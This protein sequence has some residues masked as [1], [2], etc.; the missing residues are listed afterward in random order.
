VAAAWYRARGELRRSWRSLLLLVL[1]VGVAGGAVLTTVAGARRSSTA[2][3]RFR[4]ATFASDMDVAFVDGPPDGDIAAAA[5]TIA[6]MPEVAA[7]ARFDF[8]FIVPAKSGL[9]PFL[10]F[11]AIAHADEASYKSDVDRSRI[12]AG[13]LPD[14]DAAEQIAIREGFAKEA[15]LE[16]GDRIEVE[17]YAPAQLDQLFTTG[18]A[19]P[20]AGP[21]LTL[22]VTGVVDV[23]SF[24][25]E[26]SGDF[27]PSLL[28]SPAFVAEHG[29]EIATYPG[30]FAV[31]L[32]PEADAEEVA[33]SLRERFAGAPLEI[34]LSSEV[35]RKIQSS[36]DVI[37]T[38]LG[39]CALVAA[40]AGCMAVGQALTRH[41]ASQESGD[42]WLSALGMTRWERVATKTATALP[43][44]VLGALLAVATCVLLSPLMPVGVA[45]RAEPDPGLAVDWAA[46]WIGGGVTF[47][48]VLSLSVL[49]AA[50][51]SRRERRVVA[52]DADSAASRTTRAMRR[53]NLDP[54]TTIGVG[55]ALEP[56]GGT[57]FA[58]RSAFLGAAFGVTGLV[59]VVVFVASVDGLARSPARYGAPFDALVSGFSGN[60][61]EEG[62]EELLEDPRVDGVVALGSG[63]LARVGSLEANTISL[64]SLKG[65]LALTMLEG[66]PPT[67]TAEVV[68]GRDTLDDAGLSVGDEVDVDGA[69][70][71]L[72]ATVVGIAVFPVIDERS[73][74][75]RGVLMG[76][77]DL[78][79]ITD[80]EE[81]NGDVIIDWADG[82]DAEAANAELAEATGTEVFGP[83]LPSDVNNLQDVRA[84]PRALAAFLGLLA[85]L[86]VLHALISTVRMRR[87]EL[88]VLRALGFERRQLGSTVTWQATTI[89]VVGLL[90]GVP[91]GLVVGRVVWRAVASGIGVVDD[92]VT[93]VAAVVLVVVGELVVVAA[94]AILPGRSARRVSPATALRSA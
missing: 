87:Q 74:P 94:M 83:R 43:V 29:D 46:V 88:A 45:R 62:G 23:P 18:D 80:P 8:P 79:R 17:S 19:G 86:A 61:L 52:G 13:T 41:F 5:E 64:E 48:A 75:G 56:R 1:L 25:S 2:Y 10:E 4:E 54:S 7:L 49:A 67:G 22:V 71:T 63:G 33:A 36:I 82:V 90:V 93:P 20:P 24:L 72:R 40:L 78:E 11:L 59:G 35:D 28:L 66:H 76:Q 58:V 55:M 77:E 42:R 21:R 68:L 6:A 16:V 44:A 15:E 26:S 53:A 91:V 37:V 38:A 65:D 14:A 85:S 84:L 81:L 89:G 47:L 30:G 92:P 39:L 12:L 73:S 31:R 27:Q 60:I 50:V 69:V 70:D 57:A 51:V 32:R 9:Y 3:E 34:T